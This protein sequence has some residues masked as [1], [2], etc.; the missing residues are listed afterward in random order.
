MNCQRN[1]TIVFIRKTK[2]S[3]ILKFFYI[4]KSGIL[5]DIKANSST[6]FN[7]IS[8]FLYHNMIFIFFNQLILTGLPWFN[9]KSQPKW[10]KTRLSY[11]KL[12]WVSLGLFKN[13]K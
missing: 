4:F 1:F 6:I 10:P 7:M 2:F 3:L 11:T 8:Q 5:E 12:F 13:W 9:V